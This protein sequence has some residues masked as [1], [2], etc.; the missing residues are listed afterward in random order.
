MKR[1]VKWLLG[2]IIV[3]IIL[4]IVITP[5]FL[6]STIESQLKEQIKKANQLHD[7]TH[8]KIKSYKRHWW[9][10]DV[11]IQ[12]KSHAQY[13]KMAD[14]IIKDKIHLTVHHGPIVISQNPALPH[15]IYFGL[16][17]LTGQTHIQNP[18][19]DN[20]QFKNI[21][22]KVHVG[23]L[24]SWS[25]H[26]YTYIVMPS[27]HI[28]SKNFQLDTGR[29]H[30]QH[31]ADLDSLSSKNS[32]SKPEHNKWQ[33][34]IGQST[35]H[36]LSS[37]NNQRS[38][39]IQFSKINWKTG[40]EGSP[41]KDWG[42]ATQLSIPKIN[43][44]D[45]QGNQLGMLNNFNLHTNSK[46]KSGKI[47]IKQNIKIN[48]I[49]AMGSQLNPVQLK[50]SWHNIQEKPLNK[51][52]N[53]LQ[54]EENKTHSFKHTAKLIK[55][56]SQGITNSN[57]KLKLKGKTHLGWIKFHAQAAIAQKQQKQGGISSLKPH[58]HGRL[59]LP[60]ALAN[61]HKASQQRLTQLIHN[62]VKIGQAKKLLISQDNKMMM[63]FK[64][65][66]SNVLINGHP[67]SHF[68][69]QLRQHQQHSQS[70]LSMSHHQSH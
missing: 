6:G 58:G 45:S 65:T 41:K 8:I 67:L 60:Q 14:K 42:D 22:Q 34:K 33:V 64:F 38:L 18:Y 68:W 10:S 4:A 24:L 29:I 30:I 7:S 3:V 50:W 16:G 36:Q 35:I 52:Q 15:S 39:S 2:I 55:Y 32:E 28:K 27:Y 70:G 13:G 37:K 59:S 11:T 51:L 53:V 62:F 20:L 54:N 66:K 19:K 57:A 17:A 47:S 1:F 26:S 5:Y 46:A 12:F 44:K 69:P 43:I 40:F 48:K 25:G 56:L 9:T 61:S 49:S 23:S 31:K 21:K 63:R